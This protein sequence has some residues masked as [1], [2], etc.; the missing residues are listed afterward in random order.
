MTTPPVHWHEGLFL[1]PHHFQA[2]ERFLLEQDR[3]NGRFD[4]HYNWGSR[5][6]EIDQDALKNYRFV[7]RRLEARTREGTLVVIGPDEAP[8]ELD[9][10]PLMEKQAPGALLD[11]LLAV[12]M[13]QLGRENTGGSD[14]PEARYHVD[15]PREPSPDENTGQNPRPLQFRRLNLR[16]MTAEQNTTGF[17]TLP[18]AR[19]ERSAQAGAPP[20]LHPWYIPPILACD[21]WSGLGV[22][23]LGQLYNRIGNLTKQM[24]LRVRDQRITF[25]SNAPDDRKIFERL[26]ALNEA[27]ATMH[28]YANAQ[29]VH[30]FTVYLELVRMAGKL[31]VF[32]KE[33]T[34][35][36]DMPTYDHDDLGTCFFWVKRFIDDLLTQDF[37]QGYEMRPFIGT[38][39]RMGVTIE[40]SWLAPAAQ[41]LVGVESALPQNECVRLLTGRLNMKIG[42]AE[43]V[44][45]IFRMGMRGLDFVPFPNPPRVLPPSKNITYFQVNRDA[46]KEEWD[47]VGQTYN[48]AIR[49]NERLLVGTIEGRQDITISADG[50][51][52]TLRFTLYVI[53]P[54]LNRD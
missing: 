34:L 25:D 19:L 53:P 49:L 22:Q 52:S 42:A 14:N 13:L 45:E 28:V 38:G 35:P 4:L 54:A 3:A 43:R 27:F 15:A 31:A 29:G 39:L 5:V 36:D 16:L 48:L 20:Q 51:T 30:P 6:V 18:I 12:P 50:R 46:S 37:S 17:E 41:I 23:L 8:P 44:D 33:C 10:R 7:V 2:A 21:G 1:R 47:A 9:L 24:S 40:P 26:R 32:A 11:V